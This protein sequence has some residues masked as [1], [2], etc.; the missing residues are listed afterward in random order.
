MKVI[1]IF[2]SSGSGT[3]TLAKAICER[4]GYHMID[5]DDVFWEPTDPPFTVKREESIRIQMI[6]EQMQSHPNI[7]MSGA[8]VGWGDKFIP[9][10][11]FAVYLHLPL[12]VRLERI[13]IRERNR[14]GS[15][16]LPGGD[17]YQQ[18]LDFIEWVTLYDQ[19]HESQ[20]SK[21]QHHQWM[22]KLSCPIV[23]IEQVL[24]IDELIDI[25]TPYLK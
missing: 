22:K 4:F 20:R 9:K 14:F 13:A 25:I 11:D 3:T 15:R 10:L 24:S 2:G 5:I 8:F 19:G 7:V 1:H 18:H 6:E 12:E 17:L 21:K 23:K 16:V